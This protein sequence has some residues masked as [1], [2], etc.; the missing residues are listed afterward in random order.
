M[1][2]SITDGFIYR[3]RLFFSRLF[4]SKATRI[5][6][7]LIGTKTYSKLPIKKKTKDQINATITHGK[8]FYLEYHKDLFSVLCY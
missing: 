7:R 5:W 4:D 8:K 6:F 2:F 1:L 3:I